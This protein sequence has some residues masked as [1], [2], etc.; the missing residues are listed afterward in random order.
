MPRCSQCKTETQLHS[1]IPVC[2]KCVDTPVLY[3]VVCVDG[4]HAVLKS[5][6]GQIYARTK[7]DPAFLNCLHDFP[8]PRRPQ[9]EDRRNALTALYRGSAT[10][11]GAAKRSPVSWTASSRRKKLARPL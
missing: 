3:F 2:P 9:A 8:F 10:R 4:L 1:V 11:A 7:V 6:P 5:T